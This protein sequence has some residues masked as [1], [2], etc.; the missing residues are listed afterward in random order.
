MPAKWKFSG[1]MA[2]RMRSRAG[3]GRAGGVGGGGGAGGGR[4]AFGGCGLDGRRHCAPPWGAGVGGVAGFGWGGFGWAGFGEAGFGL[5]GVAWGGVAGG[6]A[7]WG[8]AAAAAVWPGLC[9]SC[10]PGCGLGFWA[11]CFSSL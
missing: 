7:A 9:F 10:R 8:R 6:A 1:V 3:A 2:A 5:A 11:G 4:G